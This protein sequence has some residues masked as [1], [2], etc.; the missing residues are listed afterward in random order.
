MEK[1]FNFYFLLDR[2]KNLIKENQYSNNTIKNMN[3]VFNLF[4]NYMTENKLTKYTKEI[5]LQFVDYCNNETNICQSR[6]ALAKNIT[7][8]FNQLID[9]TNDVCVLI[10]YKKRIF[11]LSKDFAR[12]LT[13][14]LE[15]CKCIG[16]MQSTIYQKERA[17]SIILEKLI[18]RNCT[19]IKRINGLLL[20]E[21]FIELESQKYWERAK[22]FFKYLFEQKE[23]KKDYSK[24]IAYRKKEY[25]Y[26]TVYSIEE[27]SQIENSIDVTTPT[28]IRDYAIILLMSRYGIRPCDIANLSF[29]NIDLTNNRIHFIQQKTQEPWE[30]ELISDVKVALCNYIKIRPNSINSDKIF[31]ILSN[32]I[33]P[34]KYSTIATLTLDIISKSGVNTINRKHGCRIFRSSIASN[35]INEYIST[36][37]VRR[38]LGHSTKYALKYYAR[39]NI[40]SMR[41]CALS[42]QQPSGNFLNKIRRKV[43]EVNV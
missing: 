4:S 5:G 3:F 6:V 25:I 18:N 28:G 12:A 37:I 10:S 30:A 7:N 41:N 11:N 9:G 33:R 16:N 21:V 36:E 24:L 42:V 29:D 19:T 32:P 2:L 15:Y 17:C 34:I 31:L 40:E 13:Q 38:V 27:I 35:M 26:P 14:Y 43:G 22:P 20:Q 1:Q 8:K 23:L 39:I